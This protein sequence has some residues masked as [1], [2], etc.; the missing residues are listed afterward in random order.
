MEYRIAGIEDFIELSQM[1]WD[2]KTEGKDTL[3]FINKDIF[4]KECYKFFKSGLEEGNWTHWIALDNNMIVSHISINHIRKIPKPNRIIDEYG[5]VTNIYTKP[6]Y[7][8][9][10]IGSKLMDNVKTW[11]TEKDLEILIVWPSH[12]AVKFY[13]RK[14]FKSDND[15]MELFIRF[16]D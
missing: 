10:G 13:E 11:A 16:D 14:G 8:G 5:Y 1:R 9:K 6:S 7:R 4:M 3:N 15:I 2:F 12:E